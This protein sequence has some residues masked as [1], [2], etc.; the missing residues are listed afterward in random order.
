MGGRSAALNC[1]NHTIIIDS[2]PKVKFFNTIVFR[3]PKTVPTTVRK[4]LRPRQIGPL[5]TPPIGG[6]ASPP[7]VSTVDT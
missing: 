7:R 4:T 3:L 6:E 5:N 2:E 1:L